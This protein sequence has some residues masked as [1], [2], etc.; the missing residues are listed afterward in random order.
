[1]CT[2]ATLW[3]AFGDSTDP[4]GQQRHCGGPDGGAL[5]QVDSSGTE[6]RRGQESTDV[7]GQQRHSGGQGGRTTDAGNS[8]GTEVSMGGV[9]VLCRSTAADAWQGGLGQY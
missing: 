4:D 5:T 3:Q 9:G 1:M 2:A 6:E 8:S 7:G